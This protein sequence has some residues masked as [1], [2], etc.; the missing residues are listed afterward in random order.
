MVGAVED[1]L[2]PGEP[3]GLQLECRRGAGL[4]SAR[5]GGRGGLGSRKRGFEDDPE[6][7]AAAAR[8]GNRGDA[9][10][11]CARRWCGMHS[12]ETGRQV[13][14]SR[15]AQHHGVVLGLDA[16]ADVPGRPPSA[17]WRAW[18]HR[19]STHPMAYS[20]DSKYHT[21]LYHFFLFA[22]E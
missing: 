12:S 9:V 11:P 16:V 17:L 7:L 5:H 13:P 14:P 18:L 19:G 4:T 20:F 1:D 10:V 21:P 15:S 8:R 2:D 3:Y 22:H 6:S